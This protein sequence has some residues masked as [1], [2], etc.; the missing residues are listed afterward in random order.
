MLSMLKMAQ[1]LAAAEAELQ[2]QQS[3]QHSS[4]APHS[5]HP[6]SSSPD[7]TARDSQ[8]KECSVQAMQ[9]A[10]T[11]LCPAA[12]VLRAARTLW[13]DVQLG[14]SVALQDSTSV[15]V[16]SWCAGVAAGT[17][18]SV[19]EAWQQE[20]GKFVVMAT[21]EGQVRD[22]MLASQPKAGMVAYWRSCT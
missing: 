19:G 8:A 6:S 10:H 12:A 20:H 22:W 11:L 5:H 13:E 17:V 16:P 18:G 15:E 2:V 4:Q 21:P 14:V 1:Q 7:C 3:A 9:A